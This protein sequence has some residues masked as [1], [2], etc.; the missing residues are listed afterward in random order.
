MSN[1]IQ[2]YW[3]D[4]A[5]VDVTPT[6]NDVYFRQLEIKTAIN[7]LKPLISNS[8]QTLVDIGC[9]DGLATIQ[10]AK[11]FPNLQ[12]IGI[13]YAPAMIEL[14]NQAKI[15]ANLDDRVQFQAGNILKLPKLDADFVL[16]MRCL[17]NLETVKNQIKALK[18]IHECLKPGAIALLFENFQAGYSNLNRIRTQIGLPEIPVRWHNLPFSNEFFSDAAFYGSNDFNTIQYVPFG[19][20]YYYTTR[21]IYSKMCQIEGIQPDYQHPIHKLA[22]DLPNTLASENFCPTYLVKLIKCV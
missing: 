15:R 3:N 21:V 11:Q 12:I 16:T 8:P 6:T 17:I 20:T 14:A 18:R 13:D 9:G 10:I 4:R 1:Q 2:Q 22:I 19:S 7:N 5:T